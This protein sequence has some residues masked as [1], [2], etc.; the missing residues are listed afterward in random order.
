MTPEVIT[1]AESLAKLSVQG[2]LLF[3]IFMLWKKL[4]EKDKKS[5]DREDKADERTLMILEVIKENTKSN[6]ELKS[7]VQ[8]STSM[9]ERVFD[10]LSRAK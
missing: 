2:I 10:V 5:N 9:T 3:F 8:N 6:V 1:V 7:A 4:E